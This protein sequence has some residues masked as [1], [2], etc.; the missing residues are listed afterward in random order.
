MAAREHVTKIGRPSRYTE[1]LA[2]DLCEHLATGR[3]LVSWCKI[4]NHPVYTTVMR[5]LEVNE[6]FRD[7]YVRAR[8]AQ[9][10]YLA[11]EVVDI[12]TTV[13]PAIKRTVTGTGKRKRVKEEHGDAVDRARLMMDARKW[14]AGKLAP[15]KYG[16]RQQVDHGVT[17]SLEGLIRDSMAPPDDPQQR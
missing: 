11:E 9:A 17:E 1:K 7:M 3:S 14:Y 15:R 6:A 16:E 13:L 2:R 8:E 12:A 10:D 5:W 4:D